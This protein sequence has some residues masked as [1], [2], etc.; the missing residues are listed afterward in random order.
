MRMKRIF[1]TVLISFVFLLPSFA[2]DSSFIVR[3]YKLAKSSA[4]SINLEITD[5]IENRLISKGENINITRSLDDYIENVS[6]VF[7]YRATGNSQGIYTL[8]F[9]A[10]NSAKFKKIKKGS[11]A[12]PVYDDSTTYQTEI[13]ASLS[14]YYINYGFSNPGNDLK[15]ENNGSTT[16][17]QYTG[18]NGYKYVLSGPN[19][20][21]DINT[22]LDFSFKVLDKEETQVQDVTI[23]SGVWTVEGVLGV[24]LE[25]KSY[26][27]AMPGTYVL[28]VTITLE[29][30]E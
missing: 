6:A 7:S 20:I 1:A 14:A 3:A 16:T 10:G 17:T 22:S 19:K 25:L 29:A 30:I 8:S 2:T 28:P 11:E 4:P 5:S 23:K 27:E 18:N 26:Q 13:S 24:K 9:S 12:K 15:T 21:E